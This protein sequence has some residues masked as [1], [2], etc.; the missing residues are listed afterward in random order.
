MR[1]FARAGAANVVQRFSIAGFILLGVAPAKHEAGANAVRK[2]ACHA[3]S[4][5]KSMG[6]EAISRAAEGCGSAS[7]RGRILRTGCKRRGGPVGPLP[8]RVRDR[9]CRDPFSQ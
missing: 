3:Y 6:T 9:Q 8:L 4:A 7:L 5:P 2:E 1:V